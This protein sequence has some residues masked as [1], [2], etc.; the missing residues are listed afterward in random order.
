M[1][2]LLASILNYTNLPQ[3][4][5]NSTISNVLSLVFSITAA[6]SVLMVIIGGFRYVAAHG[7]PSATA[8]A[9]QTIMYAVIGLV[10]TMAAYSIVLFVIKGIA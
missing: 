1:N 8:Q 6:I 3:P 2:T 10:V 4:N 5:T 7:D 9:R